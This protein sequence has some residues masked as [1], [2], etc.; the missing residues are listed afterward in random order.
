LKEDATSAALEKS[1]AAANPFLVQN[2]YSFHSLFFLD[3]LR[4]VYAFS[5]VLFATTLWAQDR[6]VDTS[7]KKAE[8]EG[9]RPDVTTF[10]KTITSEDLRTYLTYLASDELEGRETGQPGQQKAADY[11]AQQLASFGI[12]PVMEDGTYFQEIAYTAESWETIGLQV[13]GSDYRH[14]RDFYSFP[15]TNTD[16]PNQTFREVVFLGYGIDDENYSD[17]AGQNVTG[18]VVS[19]SQVSPIPPT[20][21]LRS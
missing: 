17:Y 5:L 1:P 14:L 9:V 19:Y 15:A 20:T 11:L 7:L 18:K 6:P 12:P 10:S 13:N 3:M 2:I 21:A 16:Q 4:L 8:D